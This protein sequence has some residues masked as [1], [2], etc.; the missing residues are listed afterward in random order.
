MADYQI[1]VGNDGLID[2]SQAENTNN[3]LVLHHDKNWIYILNVLKKKQIEIL[4]LQ[5]VF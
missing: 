5:L 3:M 1:V 2:I 4:K